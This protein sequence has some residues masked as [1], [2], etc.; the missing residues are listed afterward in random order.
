MFNLV[1]SLMFPLSEIAGIFSLILKL[2]IH[3][4]SSCFCCTE[5]IFF[6]QGVSLSI[7]SVILC[8]YVL[9]CNP[10]SSCSSVRTSVLIVGSLIHLELS[11][12]QWKR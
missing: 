9:K 7:V 12:V 4:L 3:L 1:I 6:F 11:S 8:A 10:T 5:A 2:P